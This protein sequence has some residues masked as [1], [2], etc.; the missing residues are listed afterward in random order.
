MIG[1]RYA[2]LSIVAVFA[3]LLAV[4][5]ACGEE[6]TPTATPPAT[7]TATPVATPTPAPTPPAK[8]EPT[9]TLNVGTRTRSESG[10]LEEGRI[11]LPLISTRKMR[12]TFTEP[13]KR[14]AIATTS[15]SILALRN[16]AMS[17]SGS[18]IAVNRAA[19]AAFSSTISTIETPS[20]FSSSRL[21]APTPSY[22]AT[23]RSWRRERTP[24]IRR[25]RDAGSKS[26]GG[27][28]SSSTSS[29]IVVPSSACERAAAPK[30]S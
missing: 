29:M 13:S 16:G 14:R 23:S 4:I 24:P 30:A 1:A 2:R 18:S 9:G 10:G 25:M 21:I 26:D 11:S 20:G 22:P 19:S 8:V 7:P 3:V 6:A 27:A 12:F 28:T 17:T 15:S 5:V